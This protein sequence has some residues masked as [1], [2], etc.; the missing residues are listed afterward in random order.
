MIPNDAELLESSGLFGDVA[1][2]DEFINEGSLKEWAAGARY[3]YWV[4]VVL[5][6]SF[7]TGLINAAPPRLADPTWQLNFVSLL[8]SSGA[9][10][11]IGA[12]LI[13]LARIFDQT[14]RQLLNRAQL[15]RKLA[16]WVALGWLLLIPLQLFVGTRL[17]NSKTTTELEQIRTLEGFAKSVRDSNSEAELRQAM[18]Q[19][20][21]QPPLPPLTVPL[22]VA[23]ANLLAQFQKTINTAKNNQDLGS[24]NRLQIW[25]KEAFRNSIQ[26]LLLA[27]GFLAIGKHRL[28]D[29]FPNS[30]AQGGFRRRGR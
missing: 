17:M 19:V 14:D 12:L 9:V 7:L 25:L 13:C 28:L 8:L 27:T 30:N 4:G 22:P 10:T 15:V 6:G 20:P 11:L 1:N 3:T 5:L 2:P 23:K 29:E 21:N 16:P 24:A 26:S 18:A